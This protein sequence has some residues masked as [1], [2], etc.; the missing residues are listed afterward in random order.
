MLIFLLIFTISFLSVFLLLPVVIPLFKK[1]DIK[2]INQ[3]KPGGESIAE[4]GGLITIL[5][6]GM[7]LI[8]VI[9]LKTFFNLFPSVDLVIILAVLS[10]ELFI[11]I[12]GMIDDLIS[13]SQLGKAV[14]PALA[15]LP[16]IALEAGQTVMTIPFIGKID[17]GFTYTLFL[18]PFG[19]TGAVNA[20]NMLA[21]FNGLEAGMGLIMFTG[22]LV[23]AII[24]SKIIAM[25]ILVPMIGSLLATLWYN[26]YPAEVLIGDVGTLS[27][28]AMLA[29]VVIIG[30]FEAAGLIMIVH[31]L[32]I[33]SLKH[34]I[35]FPVNI[36]GALTKMENYIVL[37]QAR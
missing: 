30:D 34:S 21:G 5:G 26:W 33:L 16:L 18:L 23:L 27:I 13:M 3:N 37:I 12:I 28:G 8:T 31:I 14:V 4:M 15:S 10:V 29:S 17:F 24:K 35:N 20:V 19:M 32:L 9:A 2:G 36:G 7:G 22:L 1:A 11:I 25:V 6:F